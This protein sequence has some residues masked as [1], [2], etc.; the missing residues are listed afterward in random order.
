MVIILGRAQAIT[1]QKALHYGNRMCKPEVATVLNSN[2]LVS[3]SHSS[4]NRNNN[5][6]FNKIFTG[7]TFLLSIFFYSLRAIT[8][9]SVCFSIILFLLFVARS[10]KAEKEGR[11]KK[12]IIIKRERV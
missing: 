3:P 4:L 8:D 11:K 1:L 9:I 12:S 5:I 10:G 7:K 6:L 2:Y